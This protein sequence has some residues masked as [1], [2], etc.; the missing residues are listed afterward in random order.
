MCSA[1]VDLEIRQWALR[2]SVRSCFQAYQW[3]AAQRIMVRLHHMHLAKCQDLN[4][5]SENTGPDH[6]VSSR[7]LSDVHKAYKTSVR[8]GKT[9][10]TAVCSF[11]AS[12]R[13]SGI[14]PRVLQRDLVCRRCS[15]QSVAVLRT[16]EFLEG[17]RSE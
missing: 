5:N 2:I 12:T 13:I 4:V 17:L 3:A 11:D 10:A 8:I 6:D 9:P 15:T 14:G 16:R 7:K 1:D